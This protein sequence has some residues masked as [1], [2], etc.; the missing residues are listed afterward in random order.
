MIAASERRGDI[1]RSYRSPPHERAADARSLA[2]IILGRSVLIGDGPWQE[3]IAGGQRTV[4]IQHT[5]NGRL[6]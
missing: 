2:A 3:A 6:F 1:T 5:S 4:T